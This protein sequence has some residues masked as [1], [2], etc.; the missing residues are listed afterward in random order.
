MPTP[1]TIL[2]KIDERGAN[3]CLRGVQ[4]PRP[5]SGKPEQGRLQDI[6]GLTGVWHEQPR[7][8]QQS[9][10]VDLHELSE[11]LLF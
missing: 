1:T 9:I 8:P 11:G 6:L 2:C 10:T 7:E 4:L 5:V 3:I